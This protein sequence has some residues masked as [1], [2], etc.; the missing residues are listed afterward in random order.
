MA[1]KSKT[2]AR[3]AWSFDEFRTFLAFALIGLANTIL[4]SLIHASNYLI[5]PY[6]R[7]IVIL[8]EVTPVLLT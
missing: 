6:P 7:H 3:T 2:T 4:P 1:S 5:I 8:I